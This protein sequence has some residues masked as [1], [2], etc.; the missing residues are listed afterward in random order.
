MEEYDALRH[1]VKLFLMLR[2]ITGSLPIE[3]PNEM[4]LPVADA[5]GRVGLAV[6][7][8]SRALASYVRPTLS[9]DSTY[10]RFVNGEMIF[11]PSAKRNSGSTSGRMPSLP[12]A[13]EGT[14]E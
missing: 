3:D 14:T 11:V 4:D 12:R 5:A 9:G 10:D 6:D 1:N 7:D 8:L 13:S 2:V